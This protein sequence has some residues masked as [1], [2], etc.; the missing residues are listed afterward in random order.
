[1]YPRLDIDTE[2]RKANAHIVKKKIA[3]ES[4]LGIL[5]AWLERG[6]RWAEEKEIRA[7]A[8]A[9]FHERES[10]PR[11]SGANGAEL[12]TKIIPTVLSAENRGISGYLTTDK[13]KEPTAE[14]ANHYPDTADQVHKT[15]K[16]T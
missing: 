2:T 14:A 5:E 15:A 3:V 4:P 9:M 13:P 6:N 16:R 11:Q 10:D 7:R 1:M 8:Q 12:I